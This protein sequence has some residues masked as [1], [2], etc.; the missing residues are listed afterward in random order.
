M[1]KPGD[2]LNPY[3]PA[4]LELG[5]DGPLARLQAGTS[6]MTPKM[7]EMFKDPNM[8]TMLQSMM[9]RDKPGETAMEQVLREKREW[10]AADAKSAQLKERGNDA[11]RAGDYKEAYKIY[12][13]CGALSGHE[14]LYWLNRAAVALKLQIYETAIQDASNAIEDNY[15]LAKAHFRRGTAEFFL[16]RW[17]DAEADFAQALKHQ[18]GDSSVLAQA[19]ELQRLRGLPEEEQAAWI[20][21]QSCRKPADLFDLAQFKK[22]IEELTGPIPSL[23]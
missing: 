6:P 23:F 16:G 18:P 9:P 8:L 17:S 20:R 10:A 12:T 1:F 15:S 14:P 7:A 11:F 19:A 22:D 3:D 13:A 21:A 2:K 5:A 4:S